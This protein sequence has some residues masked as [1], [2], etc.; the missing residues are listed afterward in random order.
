MKTI[1]VDSP[2]LCHAAKHV[3]GDLTLE[4]KKVGVIFGFLNQILK[5]AKDLESHKLVFL[6]DSRNSYRKQIF[7]GYKS[8]R[9][10]KSDEDK[11]LDEIAFHQ[12][13]EL[14][15][16]ILPEIGFKNIFQMDGYEA[17]DLIAKIVEDSDEEFIVVSSDKDLLQILK[18]NVSLFFPRTKKF[19][20][21]KDFLTEYPR[22]LPKQWSLVKA[23]AG[24]NSDSIPGIEGIGEKTA[25]K[26]L[27]RKL[28]PTH[29]AYRKIMDSTAIINRNKLLTS[30]PFEGLSKPVIVSDQLF[31]NNLLDVCTRYQFRSLVTGDALRRWEKNL[32]MKWS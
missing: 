18:P 26:Y 6:W 16:D 32:N 2:G 10:N 27:Q 28:T 25:V 5:L 3:M 1:L 14:R 31:M 19:Y 23:I 4:E 9:N 11:L 21:V 7:S 22:I 29:S 20:T 30:L 24:C 15:E 13:D 12:F 17:D 8:S